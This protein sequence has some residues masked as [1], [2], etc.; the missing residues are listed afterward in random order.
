[1]SHFG[2]ARRRPSILLVEDDRFTSVEIEAVLEAAGY[3][4]VCASTYSDGLDFVE[5]YEVTCA[6][7]DDVSP[8]QSSVTLTDALSARRIPFML[9]RGLCNGR[10]W[11]AVPNA[12]LEPIRIGRTSVRRYGHAVGRD[13]QTSTR[14][15]SP[16][17]SGSTGTSRGP[18]EARR[19][20][21]GR[22]REPY[23]AKV[24][25]T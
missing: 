1:M 4:V 12:P 7:L 14:V 2:L 3:E 18:Q 13:L 21:P 16:T 22:F 20:Q 9:T 6:L 10:S 19:P 11:P 8:A 24:P 15:P 25:L 5:R 17:R 23:P